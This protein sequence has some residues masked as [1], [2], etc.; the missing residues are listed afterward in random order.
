M[1]DDNIN[2]MGSTSSSSMMNNCEIIDWDG[3]FSSSCLSNNLEMVEKGIC[4]SDQDDNNYY[5]MGD[6]N[7]NVVI[8][9]VKEGDIIIGGGHNNNNNNNNC[10]YKGKMVM[11]KRSTIASPRIAFQTKSVEDVLDDG[12]RWRKYGQKAV[13]HSNHPRYVFLFLF[14][15]FLFIC[16]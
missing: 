8:G 13:K 11:G 15:L 4:G 6:N 10:K 9:G 2:Q 5:P 1:G 7:N 3:L 12:Y 16:F 14:I